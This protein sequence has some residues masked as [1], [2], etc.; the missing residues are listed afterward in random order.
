MIPLK[1]ATL[2]AAMLCV[3]VSMLIALGGCA[4]SVKIKNP[5][6][7]EQEFSRPEN[8]E[9]ELHNRAYPETFSVSVDGEAM[10][11]SQFHP[12]PPQAGK[13]HA[14]A[15]PMFT[16]DPGKEGFHSVEAH[17][18]MDCPPFTFCGLSAKKKFK[19]PRIQICSDEDSPPCRTR[20]PNDRPDFNYLAVKETFVK[21]ARVEVPQAPYLPVTIELVPSAEE[22]TN[23]SLSIDNVH[24]AP[25]GH[26]VEVT[27]PTDDRRAYFWIK[28]VHVG[29]T[30]VYARGAGYDPNKLKVN[31]R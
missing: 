31:V 2:R 12:F 18:S 16:T 14:G 22:G 17:A 20:F 9:M 21:K 30:F 25:A 28:G 29:V 1:K 7:E 13:T 27:I 8:F 15:M 26:K 4:Y 23:V 19:A 5:K 11:I 6:V 24:F 10:N 3:T